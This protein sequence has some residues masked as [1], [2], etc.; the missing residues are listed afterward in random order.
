MAAPIQCTRLNSRWR[1][2]SGASAAA[3]A[4]FERLCR[5]W[6]SSLPRSRRPSFVLDLR[7]WRVAVVVF[8]FLLSLVVGH[9][10]R[11]RFMRHCAPSARHSPPAADAAPWL[12]DVQERCIRNMLRGFITANVTIAPTF[13][14]P[15][16]PAPHQI[17][18]N[19][20]S[21]TSTSSTC[22][23]RIA[24]VPRG[25]GPRHSGPFDLPIL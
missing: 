9:G 14:S 13:A 19:Q 22:L 3:R 24:Q 18:R 7:D 6:Y 25:S 11:G 8:Q 1:C 23:V 17:V 20:S 15:S 10:L 16:W 4:S 21:V 12:L 2:C 5:T